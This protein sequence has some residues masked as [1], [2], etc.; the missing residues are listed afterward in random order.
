MKAGGVAGS[1][2]RCLYKAIA[3]RFSGMGSTQANEAP[4]SKA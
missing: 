4:C 1:K 3:A 2:P